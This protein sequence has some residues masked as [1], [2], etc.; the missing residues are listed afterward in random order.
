MSCCS[1]DGIRIAAD[2]SERKADLALNWLKKL[3]G[4]VSGTHDPDVPGIDLDEFQDRLGYRFQEP[5]L[6]VLA[7]SHRSWIHEQGLDRFQSNERLEFLGD[8]V[9]GLLINETLFH[10][11]PDMAEGD[12]TQRKSLLASRKVLALVGHELELNRAILLSPNERESGGAMRDSIL[13]DGVEA[14]LGAAY[15]DGGLEAV[16][17][18]VTR[19]ILDRRK[20]FLGSESHRNFKSMLQERIQARD[21]N[22]PRY[23]VDS[24]EGP[25]HS[26]EFFVQVLVGGEVIAVGRGRSKK[27]AEKEAA[28]LALVRLDEMTERDSGLTGH[29]ETVD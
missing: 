12:L 16:R 11:N 3:L 2:P 24:T 29:P 22:P 17:P 14:I 25:D 19:T 1:W 28:R 4:V 21:Q 8:S 6:L 5:Q 18:I 20:E 10:D 15:L 7:L 13:A 23:R 27:D 26:K 9:L